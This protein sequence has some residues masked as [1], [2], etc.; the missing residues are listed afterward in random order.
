M[1]LFQIVD[2]C[3]HFE[4]IDQ[5]VR[6]LQRLGLL[7]LNGAATR[8]RSLPSARSEEAATRENLVSHS[9]AP[10]VGDADLKAELK[11]INKNLKQMIELQKQANI[12]LLL[13]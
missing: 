10:T 8:E 7:D 5:Y 1:I 2:K 12:F 4:W 3:T 9:V 11:K 6:R 13:L